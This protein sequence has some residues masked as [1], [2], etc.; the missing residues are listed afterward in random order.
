MKFLADECCDAGLVRQMR[1]YGYDA[2]YVKEED[3]GITDSEVLKKA[4]S[5]KRVLIT[6]D[7]DFG[8]LVFRLKKKVYGIILLRFKVSEKDKK[9][10]RL[11]ALIHQKPKILTNHFIVVDAHK[12]RIRPL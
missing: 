3:P 4:Y 10:H 1:E 9:W 2:L 7:K 5:E 6:E 8:E 11:K 12:F